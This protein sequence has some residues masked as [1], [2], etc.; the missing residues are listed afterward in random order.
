MVIDITWSDNMLLD[1]RVIILEFNAKQAT[2]SLPYLLA[3]KLKKQTP[4]NNLA[5]YE[6]RR[7]GKIC[8]NVIVALFF[9]IFFILKKDYQA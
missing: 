2:R 8:I 4:E 6:K 3:T 1:K 5:V 7:L 9:C